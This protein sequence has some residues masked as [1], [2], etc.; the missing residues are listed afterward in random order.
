LTILLTDTGFTTPVTGF[1]L[2]MTGHTVSGSGT[3]TFTAF[4]DANT[5]FA[6]TIPI[7]GPLNPGGT[8][9]A[10]VTPSSNPYSLTEQVVLTATAGSTVE[11]STDS[12]VVGFGV[13]EPASLT[14]L[15]SALVG[16]GWLG[17]RRRKTV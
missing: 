13:P 16:L 4:T 15:G 2:A 6:M 7:D 1:N 11:W 10:N 5:P 12:S 3:A 14:L 8:A 17:R 9:S